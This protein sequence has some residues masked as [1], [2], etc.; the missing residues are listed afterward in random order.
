[1][2]VEDAIKLSDNYC[3]AAVYVSKF[4]IVIIDKCISKTK[5]ASEDPK[6]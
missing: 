1:L 6:H 4:F 2:P 3:W 5:K